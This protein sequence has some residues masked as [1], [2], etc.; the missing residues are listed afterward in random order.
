MPAPERRPASSPRSSDLSPEE[1]GRVTRAAVLRPMN[2]TVLAIGV[3]FSTASTAWW[4]LGLTLATYA[5]LILLGVKDP[6]LRSR[7]LGREDPAIQAHR[8]GADISPE[9]RARWLPRG[10]TRR[11]VEAALNE[12][13]RVVAAIENSDDV[14][15]AVL[16]DTVPRLHATA[17]RLVDV[18]RNKE[19]AAETARDL[20]KRSGPT[21][22]PRTENAQRLEEKMA[23]A[24][25]EISATSEELL[26]LRAKVV[27]ISIDT[28]NADRAT[29]LNSSL[30]ELNARLEALGDVTSPES[31][32]RS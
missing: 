20:R 10:E 15:R 24:D 1:R 5:A 3:V 28:D 21:N 9:R 18:A 29:A 19:T 26:D 12:Y 14:T 25:A 8:A 13:R 16:E 6:V 32:P 23:A 30:D 2:L 17:D 31:N 11:K 7:V 4:L 22:S 27:R